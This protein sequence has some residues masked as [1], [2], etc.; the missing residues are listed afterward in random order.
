M[1]LELEGKLLLSCDMGVSE[2][3]SFSG[4]VVYLHKHDASGTIGYILNRPLADT[5]ALLEESLEIDT[6][7]PQMHERDLHF[8]GPV[9]LS[10]L[11]VLYEHEHQVAVLNKRVAIEA[12]A[13]GAIVHNSFAAILGYSAWEPGQLLEEIKNHSWQ[14]VSL[15][16]RSVLL[17]PHTSVNDML[18]LAYGSQVDFCLHSCGSA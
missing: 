16:V 5:G 7:I 6:I 4:S 3:D 10:R 18:R 17:Q 9:S 1:M 2:E 14:V 8:G 11:S 13:S 12:F 15:P